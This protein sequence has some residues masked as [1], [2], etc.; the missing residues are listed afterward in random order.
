MPPYCIFIITAFFSGALA[1][2]FLLVFILGL[3]LKWRKWKWVG[4]ISFVVCSGIVLAAIAGCFLVMLMIFIQE[5]LPRTRH[6]PEIKDIAGIYHFKGITGGYSPKIEKSITSEMSITLQEDGSFDI[7]NLPSK[8][9][10]FNAS[11]D[12]YGSGSGTWELDCDKGLLNTWNIT[13]NFT[14]SEGLGS[15]KGSAIDFLILRKQKPPYSIYIYL[16]DP[17][18]GRFLKFE[19]EK[20]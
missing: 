12:S 2:I 1:A 10:D 9:L 18:E 8:R 7:N 15:I 4:G 11:E 6:K 17:D 13:L 16:G 14:Q 3:I 20:L 19:K 5:E